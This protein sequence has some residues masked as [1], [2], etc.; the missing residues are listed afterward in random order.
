MSEKDTGKELG[1]FVRGVEQRNPHEP[2][3]VQAVCEVASSVMPMLRDNPAYR[4]ARILE[5]MTEPDRIIIFRVT[6]EADDG[7]VCVNRAWRVQFNRAI[8]PYKGGLR[9][10][11]SVN[12]SILKFLGFE[13]TFKNSLTGLPMGSGKGGSNFHPRG[14]SEREVMRFCQSFMTELFRHIG[15]DSD[16]PAGDIGVGSREIGFLFGQYMRLANEF[17]G[18]L[19]GKGLPYGGSAIRQEATGYGT[20]CFL[21]SMLERRGEGLDGKRIVISGAGN[22]A[23]FAAEKAIRAGGKV[24]TLSDSDGFVH[25]RRGLD[26]EALS[27]VMHL[28]LEERGRLRELEEKI[29]GI[30]YTEGKAP[31]GIPCDVAMPCATQN[32]LDRAA[33]ETL[34]DNGVRAVVEGANMPSTRD[35]VRCFRQREVLFGPGKAANAGGVAVSGLEQSQNATRTSWSRTKVEKRLHEIMRDIHDRCV[36]EMEADGDIDYLDAANRAGFRKVADAMLAHGVV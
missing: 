32:E 28:K 10:H 18:A 4:K 14:R 19:T 5:R 12:Q 1:D 29:P 6:W 20:V 23:L 25:C 22:V 24:L 2:E 11:Q 15:P 7:S 21:E 26:E 16:V 8:G 30:E 13:Q 36:E 33:A 31:W 34:V 17:E 35:A 9:F 3:F 27:K